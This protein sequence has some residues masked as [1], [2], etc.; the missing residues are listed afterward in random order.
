MTSF[1]RYAIKQPKP[2]LWTGFILAIIV[3]TVAIQWYIYR[4]SSLTQLQLI[5]EMQHV[6]QNLE[7]HL[8]IQTFFNR[9]LIDKSTKLNIILIRQR[10]HLAIQKVTDKQ[11]RLELVKLQGEVI[12]LN[13]ELVFYRIINKGNN[14]GKLQIYEFKIYAYDRTSGIYNYRIIITQG[15]EISKALAGTIIINAIYNDDEG[16]EITV[17]KR[18]LNLR[19]VQVV[20]G[21]IEIFNNVKP[22]KIII[23]IKQKKKPN[24]SKTFDWDIE[25]KY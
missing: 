13:K 23:I 21:Q 15:N 2:L 8:N 12:K 9:G 14:S 22:N 6:Q 3:V 19:Y 11:L 18:P 20:K 17:S 10:Q 4:S 25:D 1:A 7:E 16:Q 24:I 5:V